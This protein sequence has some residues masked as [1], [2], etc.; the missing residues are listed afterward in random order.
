[1]THKIP[2]TPFSTRLSGSAKE[3]ERRLRNIFSGPKKRPPALFLALVFAACL[4]CGNLVSCNQRPAEPAVV[5]ET[6]YY[7]TY[8]NCIE[9]PALALPAG[10]ENGAVEAINAALTQL[11]TE[12]DDEHYGT[13]CLFYPSTT[14]RYLNL[15]FY[16]GDSGYG[17]DGQVQ[18]WV[19]D[20][21]EGTQV[22]AEEALDLAGTT[23]EELF[24][25]LEAVIAADPEDP[26]KLYQL[27][28]PLHI[29]GFRMKEDGQPVFY[30]S[31]VVD[32]RDLG[33]DGFLDE[34]VRL[35]IW[36]AGKFSR[37]S[38]MVSRL[39]GQSPL[40]P[41][42]ETDRLDPPL[43]NQWYFAGEEPEEGFVRRYVPGEDPYGQ[44]F[45]SLLLSCY[46]GYQDQWTVYYADSHT[47]R[48]TDGCLRVGP[49]T[50]LGEVPLDDAAA[51]VY[52]V[53]FTFY[54]NKLYAGS[55]WG[56][57]WDVEHEVV[58]LRRSTLDGSFEALL[59]R[60]DYY[61]QADHM[62]VD[63]IVRQVTGTERSTP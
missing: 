27:F 60:I 7:D 31:A 12:Q 21:R 23:Q 17:S 45:Y 11:G 25:A 19:Y 32:S 8:G 29:L 1:M 33:E 50:Y 57:D 43:W 48:D 20:K 56:F 30:L 13:L 34:W 35:Y 62:T 41:A 58:V 53:Y 54:Q 51:A 61:L 49:A 3:T 6:Q 44:N 28:D 14:E 16:L 18:T 46:A 26:R 39:D 63:E 10:A 37:Y 55:V 24:Q 40:V 9:I 4:L 47:D 5:M 2:P 59:G 22:T 36:D 15:T 42:E 52:D 38:C